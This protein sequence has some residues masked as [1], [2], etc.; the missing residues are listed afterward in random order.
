VESISFWRIG[1]HERAID[2][3]RRGARTQEEL[4]MS[5]N[6]TSHFSA[7][8]AALVLINFRPADRRGPHLGATPISR[9]EPSVS[10]KDPRV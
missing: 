7:D 8:D 5:N 2:F 3:D 10:Q 1:G 6:F 4:E 9:S